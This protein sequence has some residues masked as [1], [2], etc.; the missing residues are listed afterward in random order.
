MNYLMAL[1]PVV[2]PVIF[3]AA[4]HYYKDRHL[5]EPIGNLILSFLLG[6]ASF[7]VGIAMY[8]GL[9]LIGLRFDA[10]SLAESNRLGLFV[11]S[12]LVIGV[13][14]ELAK[15]LPFIPVVLRF[16]AF[17]EPL[18]GIIYASF[19]ALGF[20]TVE[21]IQYLQFLEAPEAIARGFAAPLVHI[22]FVSIWAFHTGV[23]HLKGKNVLATGLAWL[24]VAALLHGSYDFLV[25]AMPLSALP[26]AALLVLA[27]WLWRMHLIRELTRRHAARDE[28]GTD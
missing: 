1:L 11:Y 16:K 21:N 7:Y 3:W 27:V 28:S 9:D 8:R 25:I 19:I 23:A 5:P 10:Y 6:I 22:I 12:I 18:D 26:A 24:A 2:A 4:Y 14:E 17:D 15:F 13:I 20:A